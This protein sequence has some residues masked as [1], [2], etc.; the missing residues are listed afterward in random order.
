M[1]QRLQH[2][3]ESQQFSR[4]FLEEICKKARS[5]KKQRGWGGGYQLVGKQMAL[6]FDEDSVRTRMSFESAMARLGGQSLAVG[7]ANKFSSVTRGE[8]LSDVIQGIRG[9][10]E[11][12]VI[13][14]EEGSA[15]KAAKVSNG[16]PVINAGEKGG[17]HPT[18][19]LTDIYTIQQKLGNVDGLKV[20]MVGDLLYGRTVHSLAYLLQQYDGVEQYFVAP[21]EAQMK[22]EIVSWLKGKGAV[23]IQTGN[24]EEVLPVVDC[25]YMTQLHR[26]LF[27]S[28]EEYEQA[29]EKCAI[30]PM[31]VESMQEEAILM[32]PLP[33]GKSIHPQI[34]KNP[35]AVYVEQSENKLYVVMAVLDHLLTNDRS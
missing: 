29:V 34:D 12:I 4:E 9:Y 2:I 27:G 21:E 8:S 17:Q 35:R 6:L 5:M 11:V 19:A 7:S 25:V 16:V 31:N 10:C 32:H 13:R 3:L 33:K 22:P 14:Y 26:P 28:E 30:T 20:A 18:Q 15:E 24:L 1:V 23:V